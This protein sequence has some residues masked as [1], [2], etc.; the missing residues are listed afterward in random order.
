MVTGLLDDS[1]I[2]IA[3]MTLCQAILRAISR[4]H[5]SG[6]IGTGPRSPKRGAPYTY[7][8]TGRFLVT[9]N[10]ESLRDLPELD[11]VDGDTIS[12]SKIVPVGAHSLKWLTCNLQSDVNIEER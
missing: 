6:L 11:L 1:R 9:L 5:A 10:L 8:T 12:R 7:A 2:S 4:L 3:C